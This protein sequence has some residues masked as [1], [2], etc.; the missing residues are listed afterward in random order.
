MLFEYIYKDVK[1][2]YATSKSIFK[3]YFV[4]LYLNIQLTSIIINEYLILKKFARS[5]WRRRQTFFI[6]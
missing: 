2:D 4:E 5:K 6:I 1:L 3:N